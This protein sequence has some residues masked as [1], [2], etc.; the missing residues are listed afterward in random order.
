MFQ[1][2]LLHANNANFYRGSFLWESSKCV[3]KL[4]LNLISSQFRYISQVLRSIINSKGLQIICLW[5]HQYIIWCDS[6]WYSEL[7]QHKSREIT[8]LIT[9]LFVLC[10]N[11]WVG[12]QIKITTSSSWN[13][14]VSTLEVRCYL[15]K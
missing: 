9:L 13:P 4:H 5:N 6:W 7:Y 8:L 11:S 12:L 15:S 3:S 2:D 14:S 1:L 10:N